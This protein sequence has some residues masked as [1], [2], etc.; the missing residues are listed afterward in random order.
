MQ[1]L[2]LVAEPPLK[3]GIT[4]RACRWCEIRPSAN[5]YATVCTTIAF[6]LWGVN[7]E[8]HLTAGSARHDAGSSGMGI[9]R[10]V[11]S[12]VIQS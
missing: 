6:R 4:M 5:L 10:P 12:P 9:G 3:A 7:M 1:P 8:T 2:A 11:H